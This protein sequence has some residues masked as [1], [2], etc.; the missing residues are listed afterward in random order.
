MST[1]CFLNYADLCKFYANQPRKGGRGHLL[2]AWLWSLLSQS[3]P[4]LFR[5]WRSCHLPGS[6]KEGIGVALS[7]LLATLPLLGDCQGQTL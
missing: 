3:A 7:Q 6:K 4:A 2:T 5:E 1:G